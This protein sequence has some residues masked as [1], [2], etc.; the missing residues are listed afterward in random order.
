MPLTIQDDSGDISPPV[1]TRR[2]KHI[3]KLFAFLALE[4]AEGDGQKLRAP[5]TALFAR[6]QAR[7]KEWRDDRNHR[8]RVRPDGLGVRAKCGD[9]PHYCPIPKAL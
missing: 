4:V 2:G 7:V 3:R 5:F 6:R 9:G 8:G 1:K